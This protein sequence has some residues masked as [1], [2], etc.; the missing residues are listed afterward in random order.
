[1]YNSFERFKQNKLELLEKL[2]SEEKSI[3]EISR[4]LEVNAGT[5]RNYLKLL[6][7]DYHGANSEKHDLDDYLQNKAY[8]NASSLRVKL[9]EAG[10]KEEKCE[11]CGLSEW[12]G[13]KIPLE[14]HHK[15]GNHKDNHLENLEILCSNCHGVKHAYSMHKKV[16]PQCGNEF[17]T[18]VKQQKFCCDECRREYV[19]KKFEKKCEHCGKVFTTNRADAKYCCSKCSHDATVLVN[20]TKDELTR[21]FKEHKSYL[22]VSRVY[23]VSDKAVYKWCKKLGLPVSIKEMKKYLQNL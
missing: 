22:G 16:C 14:L 7:I 5:L 20:I 3:L 6:G 1:M 13:N 23:G 21:L 19:S 10:L 18:G 8:I 17:I 15:N 2:I 9:I 4:Q 12:Q 11:C